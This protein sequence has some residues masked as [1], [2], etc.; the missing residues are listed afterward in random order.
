MVKLDSIKNIARY[1][2]RITY[3]NAMFDDVNN[4][5]YCDS[6]GEEIK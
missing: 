2:V 5:S 4:K 1:E 6:G 3:F